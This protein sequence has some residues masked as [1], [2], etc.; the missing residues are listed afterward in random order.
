MHIFDAG[1][2]V[3]CHNALNTGHVTCHVFTWSNLEIVLVF[4]LFKYVAS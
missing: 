1:P 2:F 3:H 4:I